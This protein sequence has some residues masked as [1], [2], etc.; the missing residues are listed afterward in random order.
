MNIKYTIII[1]TLNGSKYVLFALNSI[2]Y[3]RRK[4]FEVVVS[5]NHSDDGTFD[6]LSNI[7]DTRVRLIRPP[8]KLPMAGHYEFALSNAVGEW[9]SILGDDDAILPYFF[10]KLDYLIDKYPGTNI[11]SSSRAYYFWPNC[12]DLYG[13]TVVNYRGN[14][15]EKL[16]S[17]KFDLFLALLGIKSCFDLP[18]LYTTGVVRASLLKEITKKSSG[19]FYKSIIPDIYSSVAIC[20]SSSNYLKVEL[21]L[22]WVGTSNKSMAR[23]DRIYRDSEPFEG[24]E[25]RVNYNA[26]SK[27]SS[28]ISYDLHSAGI[29]NLYIYECLLQ[30]PFSPNTSI[31]H[32]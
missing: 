9:I 28:K 23:S 24:K 29:S 13:S 8:T 22:F 10:D 20:L 30:C 27:I 16:R 11:I 32:L 18:M 21:P 15:C 2:L 31:L 17:T 14:N 25:D 26:P 4:D 7:K 1:P 12:E 6:L 5:D 3:S 19:N